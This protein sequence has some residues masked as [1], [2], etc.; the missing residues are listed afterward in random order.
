M[1]D[2]Q[3][4][5]VLFW[6]QHTRG[7]SRAWRHGRLRRAVVLT[8]TPYAAR[9]TRRHNVA[10]KWRKDPAAWQAVGAAVIAA[11]TLSGCSSGTHSGTPTGSTSSVAVAKDSAM[12]SIDDVDQK[13][14][15]TSVVCGPDDSGNFVI[16]INSIQLTVAVSPGDS[17][18]VHTVT[19]VDVGG[20]GLALALLDSAPDSG[21][22]TATKDGNTYNISG[23]ITGYVSANSSQHVSKSFKIEA[24][25]P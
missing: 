21:H 22:A 9:A 5:C 8:S 18:V 20:N 10:L 17:P 7:Q 13:L 19:M 15:S 4:R 6:R 3:L 14:G 25:C 11:A 23:A 1:H 16:V 12:V 2:R 24:T